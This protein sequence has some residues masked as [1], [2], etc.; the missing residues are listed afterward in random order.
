MKRI[1]ALCLLLCLLLSGCANVFDGHYVSITPYEGQ[2]ADTQNQAVAAANYDQL[3]SALRAFTNSGSTTGVISVAHYDQGIVRQD[4]TKAI[5]KIRS[6]DPI[7]A[8]AV[9]SIQFEVGSNAGKPAIALEISYIHD[10][11]EIKKIRHVEQMEDAKTEISQELTKC[12]TGV[13]L[14]VENFEQRDIAQ[15][16]EDYGAQYPEAVMEIPTTTVNVYPQ[17]GSARV[18]ELKFTYQNNR[19]SLRSMQEQVSPIFAS[20]VLYVSGSSEPREKFSQLYAFL[21]ER[22]ENYSLKTSMTPTYSLLMHG[23]GDAKAFATVY[24]AMCRQAGL[25]CMVLSG[26]RNGEAWY[27][28][29]I[30]D[31][32]IYYHLDLLQCRENKGFHTR[33]DDQMDGYVWDYSAHAASTMQT[34]E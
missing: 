20:S 28:N 34:E 9:D 15:W 14:Y 6:E 11:V 23:V 30:K 27:W 8:Y 21:V 3:C 19:D 12:S 29:V 22:F 17:E 13:V 26:T 7:T 10:L 33:T 18:V 5:S 25:E 32:D 1:F 31:E 16:V 2:Q 4:M 24:A